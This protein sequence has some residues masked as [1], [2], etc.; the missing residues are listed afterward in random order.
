MGEG[1]ERDHIVE[2]FCLFKLGSESSPIFSWCSVH[3]L[4]FRGI[5]L[6]FFGLQIISDDILLFFFF[7]YSSGYSLIFFFNYY[8]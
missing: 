8:T 5:Q 3:F 7:N 6:I 2:K 1:A 4:C